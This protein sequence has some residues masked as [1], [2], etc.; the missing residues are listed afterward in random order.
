MPEFLLYAE[1]AATPTPYVAPL[2]HGLA[3]AVQDQLLAPSPTALPLTTF[4]ADGAARPTARLHG[5]PG[6]AGRVELCI[7][8]PEEPL[9]AFVQLST[10]LLHFTTQAG[11]GPLVTQVPEQV[12]AASGLHATLQRLAAAPVSALTVQVL[13]E[14][15]GYGHERAVLVT[16]TLG[17]VPFEAVLDLEDPDLIGAL[18]EGTPHTLEAPYGSPTAEGF[19]C[20]DQAW[21]RL[22]APF[23][24]SH[25]GRCADLPQDEMYVAYAPLPRVA[26]RA[27]L[28]LA[29]AAED[30]ADYGVFTLTPGALEW[31]ADRPVTAC[32]NAW[33]PRGFTALTV[34]G[35]GVTVS[36]RAGPVG[37]VP[38]PA[39]PQTE[40][41]LL[42]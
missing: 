28:D 24:P 25:A 4:W 6:P 15:Y 22:Q 10:L 17:N 34:T 2:P 41:N 1:G 27:A 19:I 5:I 40:D 16:C 38:W 9:L 8:A 37:N 11:G 12:F 32:G 18:R 36:N 26:L 42:F 23:R 30:A 33:L 20:G 7:S 13:A 31:K 29:T 21:L 35:T 39:G 3:T 14:G